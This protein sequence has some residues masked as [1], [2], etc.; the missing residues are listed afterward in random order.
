MAYE[1]VAYDEPHSFVI[2]AQNPSFTSRD[3]ITVAARGEGSTVHYDALLAFRGVAR[4]LDPLMGLL[5]PAPGTNQQR[6]ARRA[7]PAR[8]GREIDASL[9]ASVVG[10]FTRV[11]YATRSRLYEWTPL[12]QLRLD[13]K[14][15]LVTGATSGL[16]RETAELLARQGAHVCLVGRDRAKAEQARREIPGSE[17][18]IADFSSLAATRVFTDTFAAA[19]DQLEVIVLDAGALSHGFARKALQREMNAK[20]TFATQV[21]SQFLV[22]RELL[23]LLEAAPSARAIVVASGGMYLSALTSRRCSRRRPTTTASRPTPGRSAHR[24]R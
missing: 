8:A 22:L 10:S 14:T 7:Q 4:M 20:A 5:S 23:P 17:A 24:S 6:N 16:G 3:S 18:A 15:A 9:E 12:E 1:I 21:L 19:H 11:G 2:E 13:G